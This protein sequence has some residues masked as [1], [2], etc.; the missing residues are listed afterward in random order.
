MGGVLVLG[1]SLA[2]RTYAV[3]AELIA[4]GTEA[5][6]TPLH[7]LAAYFGHRHLL[8]LAA[9]AAVELHLMVGRTV[10]RIGGDAVGGGTLA[11]DAG[12]DQQLQSAVNR[13]TAHMETVGLQHRGKL[14]SRE[15]LAGCKRSIKNP[16]T[17]AC[18]PHASAAHISAQQ[19]C[20]CQVVKLTLHAY[21]DTIL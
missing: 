11:E 14:R 10:D 15:P 6:V 16:Q 21:K 2:A 9:A 17:L 20:G 18:T 12:I 19:S 4:L 1:R 3:N 8:G 13:R 5:P 7:Y